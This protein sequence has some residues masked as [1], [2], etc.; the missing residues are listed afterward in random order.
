METSSTY[1]K[2]SFLRFFYTL[3]L[4][5]LLLVSPGL[6]GDVMGQDQVRKYASDQKFHGQAL[7]GLLLPGTIDGAGNAVD[8]NPKTHSTLSVTAGVLNQM[9]ATQYLDFEKT[10]PAGTPVTVKLTLPASALGLVD[11]FRIQPYTNLN[12]GGGVLGLGDHWRADAAGAEFQ[13]TNLLNLL[14]GKGSVEFTI[15]PT[16]AFEGVWIE[17][18][19]VLG[20]GVSMDVYHAYIMEDATLPCDEKD[21]AI[22]VLTGVRAGTIVG[23]VANATGS[24]TDPWDIIDGDPAT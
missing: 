11:N 4:V 19:S 16:V 20:L 12:Y 3:V 7:L 5:P 18:G 10:V 1:P 6:V 13:G 22:D 2:F 21:E 23:G 15:T 24:V 8:Q 14:S 17:V 9:L